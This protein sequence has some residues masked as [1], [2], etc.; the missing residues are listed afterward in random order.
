MHIQFCGANRQVTGSCYVVDAVGMRL[1]IDCGMFQERAFIGRNWDDFPFDPTSIDAMLLTHGHLDHCGRIP[2]LTRDG[3]TGRIVT[4]RPTVELTEIVMLDSARIQ[5]E[6]V[7]YK[8]KRHERENRKSKHPYVPLYTV[9]DAEAA[10]KQLEGVTYDE[11]VRLSNHISARF[12]EAGHI[13]GSSMI[14]L[15][16]E[17]S[18][19]TR[20][21]L[22]SGDIGQWDK[23]L[24]GDPS[25]V[26]RADYVVMESTYGDRDHDDTEEIDD[27]LERIINDTVRAGGNLLVPTFAIERAQELIYH[28][29]R[30][31][32][33]KRIPRLPI[34]LDSP[35]AINVT[36]VFR[37]HRTF[38]DEEANELLN[39]GDN[40]LDFQG[41]VL[42]RTVDQS[43]A[44][45]AI[46]GTCIVLA[47]S[48]MCT[49]GRIKH[50]LVQN[51]GRPESTVLIVGYQAVGTLGRSIAQGDPEVRIHGLMRPVRA[52]VRQLHGMSAHGD[53]RALLRWLEA[54]DQPPRKLF[55]THG[56]EEV[57]LHLADEIRE[58]WR[59][60]VE[61]PEYGQTVMLT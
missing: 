24:I 14:E 47:G 57:S 28:L 44:I 32:R 31:R 26:D 41:L 11:P 61:V 38:L 60:D 4:T 33:A 43:K 45:N 40:P 55:L 52:A 21:V 36:E 19:Q 20:R 10:A 46:R 2:K 58:K 39:D 34:F 42:S 25:L 59:W 50:H 3:F 9:A 16:V 23:P 6:D 22:F 7:K 8:R 29:S 17:D 18:G 27:Q 35:M 1:V 37:R 56:E 48:G 53:H 5:E 15:T 51:I 49:G 13:L 30:L 54:L 12:L